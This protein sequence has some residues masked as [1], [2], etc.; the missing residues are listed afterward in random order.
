[1]TAFFRRN[2]LAEPPILKLCC[3]YPAIS[4]LQAVN[5]DLFKTTHRRECQNSEKR[6]L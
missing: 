6:N 4:K 3:V 2:L 1:M 5:D